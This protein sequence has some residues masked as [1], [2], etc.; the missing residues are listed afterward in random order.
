MNLTYAIVTPARNEHDNLARLAESMTAQT[1]T[2]TWWVIVDD[3]SDDGTDALAAQLAAMHEWII[4][5]APEPATDGGL[6]QGRRE[7][8]DLLA[9]RRGAEA[10]PA[11]VDVVVKVDADTSFAPQYFATLMGRF[12]A[13]PHLGIAGGSCYEQE[14]GAWKRKKVAGNHPRGASRAYRWDCYQASLRLEPKMGWDGLDEVQASMMGYRTVCFTDFGFRHH[15]PMGGRER[16]KLRASTVLGQASWY[17]GYRPTYMLAR[18]LYRTPRDP[19][20]LAMLWGYGAAALSRTPQC[21]EPGVISHLR[22]Q[23]RLRALIARGVNP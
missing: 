16:D 21:P 20:A 12:E 9:F 18:A 7:G 17:M 4:V 22:D 11:P 14:N 23:Q 2:P 19:L 5:C 13:D 6:T 8:R 15:R 1:A 10:L 3:G